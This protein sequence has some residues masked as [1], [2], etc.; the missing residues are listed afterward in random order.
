MRARNVLAKPGVCRALSGFLSRNGTEASECSGCLS[1]LPVGR[2]S[3]TGALGSAVNC[4]QASLW[5]RVTSLE[6]LLKIPC[7]AL[8]KAL[9]WHLILNIQIIQPHRS[10]FSLFY[11]ILERGKNQIGLYLHQQPGTNNVAL[12]RAN[13]GSSFRHSW[14]G[15]TIV[16]WDTEELLRQLYFCSLK[17]I[18]KLECTNLIPFPTL[19]HYFWHYFTVFR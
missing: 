17:S 10:L 8:G 12:I 11:T 2:D 14:W 15:G 6:L 7:F 18:L 5:R 19:L 9:K 13:A 3:C 4:S 1:A 16:V